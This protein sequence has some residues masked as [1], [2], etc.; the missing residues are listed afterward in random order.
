VSPSEPDLSRGAAVRPEA[1]SLPSDSEPSPAQFAG[2]AQSG[3]AQSGSAQSGSGQPGSAQPGSAQ[4]AAQARPSFTA[5]TASGQ[6]AGSSQPGY[7]TPAGAVGP[8][9]LWKAKKSGIVVFR[10]TTPLVLWWVWVAFAAANVIDVAIVDPGLTVLKVAAGLLAVTGIAYATTL[11]SRVESDDDGVTIY[12]P[13]R[14]HRAPW[15]A[16]EGIFL[17]DSVEFVCY[18]PAPKKAKTIYSWALYSSRR[19]RARSHLQRSFYSSRR[20]EISSRAPSEAADLAKQATAQLMA[21]ELGRLAVQARQQQAASAVLTSRWSWIPVA[22]I[23][24]P[25]V[26]LIVVLPLH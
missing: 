19:S 3:S 1:S 2:S 22:A 10:H 8:R 14:N 15:G 17:G 4:S 11:H 7:G 13:V 26:L 24:I 6:S 20:A 18:R 23:V 9:P 5:P 16:V 21:A 12:N 25:L